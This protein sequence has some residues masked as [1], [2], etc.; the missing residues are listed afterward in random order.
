MEI[1]YFHR[2]RNR[3]EI[4][5]VYG[6][7]ALDWFYNTR[8]GG[9]IGAWI[10]S[11]S[12]FSA[13]YGMV[14]NSSWSLRKIAPFVE[15]FDI[16]LSEFEPGEGGTPEKPYRS[17]NDFFIRKFKRGKRV[18]SKNSEDLPAFCE[19][20][21]YGY[22]RVT[23]R[24]KIPVKGKF[25]QS[26]G[27]LDNRKWAEIFKDGPLLLARLCPVD[28]HRF[29]FPVGGRVIDHYTIPGLYHSVNPLALKKKGDI[30]FTNKR[31]VSILD[32]D[33]LGKLAYMEIGAVCVGKIV[34]TSDLNEFYR[35]QEKGYFL[36]GGSSVIL[37]GTAGSWVPSED[38]VENTGKGME[39][40][41]QLGDSV[42]LKRV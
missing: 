9:M 11:G 28:Y 39:T 2:K 15:K 4:E 17:F 42:G 41:V 7:W 29:H 21:Y 13:G 14:Q 1:H 18:F 8:S 20:R 26:E 37:M 23:E 38:I 31:E 3:I 32:T 33:D 36:F 22:E 19:G 5:Q 27:L 25:L 16:D 10:S 6:S 35:G 34:Q 30:F 40:Y 12:I 24:E